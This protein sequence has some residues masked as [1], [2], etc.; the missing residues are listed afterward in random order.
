MITLDYEEIDWIENPHATGVENVNPFNVIV[1]MGAVVLDPPS[2]NWTRT[3]YVENVRKE[4]TGAEWAAVGNTVSL[5]TKTEATG[6]EK[7]TG[8]SVDDPDSDWYRDRIK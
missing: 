3:I 7:D 1:F 6:V 4:S 8:K 2:D 5:G